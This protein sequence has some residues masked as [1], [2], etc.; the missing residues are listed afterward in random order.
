MNNTQSAQ[1][2][3]VIKSVTVH[4][5]NGSEQVFDGER[6]LRV[7]STPVGLVLTVKDELEESDSVDIVGLP[8]SIR[9]GAARVHQASGIIHFG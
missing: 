8:L 9:R 5:P 7:E 3:A 1:L 6:V 4:Y 2:A